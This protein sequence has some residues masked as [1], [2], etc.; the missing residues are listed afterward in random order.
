MTPAP[1]R[2]EKI[3]LHESQEIF[4]LKVAKN[5]QGEEG[6]GLKGN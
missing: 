3:C 2:F 4:G 1:A 5:R 6:E